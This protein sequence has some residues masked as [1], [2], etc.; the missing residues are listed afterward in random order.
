MQ[1]AK[2]LRE[3]VESGEITQSVRIW[4]RPRVRVG[5]RYRLA[6]GHVRVD[7]LYE[8][9]FDDIT[10]VL[11]RRSGFLG[12]ADLLKT[13]KHGRGERVFVVEFHYEPE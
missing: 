5:Q 12:V 4:L 2:P 13:A 1:F 7:K 9:H 10:P 3:R 8:I 6:P 11:A